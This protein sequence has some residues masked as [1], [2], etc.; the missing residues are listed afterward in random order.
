MND[1]DTII[2]RLRE[3]AAEADTHQLLATGEPNPDARLL[4]LC[5]D[6]IAMAKRRDEAEAHWRSRPIGRRIDAEYD[7]VKLLVHKLRPILI[8]AAK[9]PAKTPPGLYAKVLLAR[10]AKTVPHD[11][12]QSV[13]ADILNQPG[14]RMS[15]WPAEWQGPD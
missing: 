6:G 12:F 14:I 15:I 10:A 2:A 13:C 1:P 7:H 8:R 9:M 5:A 4:D 11:L 3:L